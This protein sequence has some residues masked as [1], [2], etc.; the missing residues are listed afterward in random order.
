MVALITR[1]MSAGWGSV[2]VGAMALPFAFMTSTDARPLL[3]IDRK[4]R[5]VRSQVTSIVA[6][7]AAALIMVVSSSV[8]LHLVD[9]TS[10]V[11]GAAVAIVLAIGTWSRALRQHV[12]QDAEELRKEISALW[13]ELRVTGGPEPDVSACVVRLQDVLAESTSGL[14]LPARRRAEPALVTLVNYL[15]WL[16]ADGPEP[17]CADVEP[18]WVRRLKGLSIPERAGDQAFD[19]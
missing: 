4:G 8:L 6:V 17:S 7:T 10:W 3:M 9:L 2:L 1:S 18:S 14:L 19:L 11:A 5:P 16:S 15:V 13:V 12:H